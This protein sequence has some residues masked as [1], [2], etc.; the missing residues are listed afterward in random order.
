MI[1]L[2][3]VHQIY[4]VV[5]L[6]VRA[7]LRMKRFRF[8]PVCACATAAGPVH[9]A[10]V[11][12]LFHFNISSFSFYTIWFFYFFFNSPRPLNEVHTLISII[13]ALNDLN[14]WAFFIAIEW[15]YVW[16]C[17]VWCIHISGTDNLYT[18]KLIIWTI[19]KARPGQ[20]G[21]AKRNIHFWKGHQMDCEDWRN[22]EQRSALWHTKDE[23]CHQSNAIRGNGA[24]CGSCC[25]SSAKMLRILRTTSNT[26][27]LTNGK[28]NIL[29]WRVILISR[30]FYGEMRKKNPDTE[31]W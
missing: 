8:G 4:W 9:N 17:V 16:V 18:R 11:I 10:Y 14:E 31:S 21:E 22:S 19:S 12:H 1:F 23:K 30:S 5:P 20:A 26:N 27:P 15:C 28:W 7:C 13:S 3:N 25:K 29:R 2:W 24:L 6:T